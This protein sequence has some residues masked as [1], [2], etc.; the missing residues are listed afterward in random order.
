M[1]EFSIFGRREQ[2]PPDTPPHEATAL[3]GSPAEKAEL[4]RLLWVKY[5]IVTGRLDP[6][7]QDR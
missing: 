3:F 4:N 5:L 6:G 1:G 2:Q 7:G